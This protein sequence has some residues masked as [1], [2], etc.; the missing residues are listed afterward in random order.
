MGFDVHTSDRY[1]CM[2]V[3]I[4]MCL[5]ICAYMTCVSAC[6]HVCMC[7]CALCM[8]AL[9]FCFMPAPDSTYSFRVQANTSVDVGDFSDFMSFTSLQGGTYAL[10][11]CA[12]VCAR[13]C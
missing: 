2:Y 11:L 3:C 5:Y 13:A 6:V 10:P 1:M 7:V 9:Y 12:H 8:C 4:C